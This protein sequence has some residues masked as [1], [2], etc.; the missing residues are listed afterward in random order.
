MKAIGGFEIERVLFQGRHSLIYRAT[1]KEESAARPVV[2]KA[3]ASEYPEPA[4]IE[5]LKREHELLRRLESAEGV[6][7]SLGLV[8]EGNRHVLVLEDLAGASLR[9]LDLAGA[10]ALDEFLRL[11][12]RIA[13]AVAGVHEQRVVHKD[14]NPGNIVWNRETDELRII[15]FNIAREVLASTNTVLPS[16]ILEGTLPYVS[17]EQTGRINRSVD[18]R[19]D[20]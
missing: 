15:D 2:L 9:E 16:V 11:A 7:R 17:P 4:A 14:L 6:I 18:T 12:T 8:E 19:S 1:R 13:R 5:R 10:L 3:L 20:V